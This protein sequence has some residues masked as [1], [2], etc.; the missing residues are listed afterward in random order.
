MVKGLV[1]HRQRSRLF[2][3]IRVHPGDKVM[4]IDTGAL[5]EPL[6]YAICAEQDRRCA[7]AEI[8]ADYRL[9]CEDAERSARA[10]IAYLLPLIIERCAEVAG[11]DV[12]WV[13]FGTGAIEQW[14]GGPDAVRDYRLGI[15][16]GRA[17]AVA[18]R[19]LIQKEAD[20]G[21]QP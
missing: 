20:R 17:I 14:D 13:R 1:D 8:P 6:A 19:A 21:Q 15:A 7:C 18:I 2:G 12:D 10:A 11:R 16:A 3:W 9:P 4:T 5:V